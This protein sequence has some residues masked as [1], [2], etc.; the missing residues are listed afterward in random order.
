MANPFYLPPIDPGWGR[1]GEALAEGM[2][3]G[4]QNY[5][6]VRRY[7]EDQKRQDEERARQE[8]ERRRRE[9]YD[10]ARFNA[11]L[12]SLGGGRGPM[13]T[14]ES[15]TVSAAQGTPGAPGALGA[16]SAAGAPQP[17]T[18]QRRYV[19]ILEDRPDRPGAWIP[20][21]SDVEQSERL[22]RFVDAMLENAV[23]YGIDPTPY[24]SGA[25]TPADLSRLTTA[26]A[27]GALANE[28]LKVGVDPTRYLTGDQPDLAGLRSAI[29]AAIR[30]GAARRDEPTES[31][32]RRAERQR[33]WPV[34]Q[35]VF[36]RLRAAGRLPT[37]ADRHVVAQ[38]AANA[39]RAAG[40]PDYYTPLVVDLVYETYGVQMPF[41]KNAVADLVN[42]F[43]DSDQ[44]L[45]FGIPGR[46]REAV[47][48]WLSGPG[49]LRINELAL[50]YGVPAAELERE[51]RQMLG[52]Q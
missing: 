21:P 43:L 9:A 48:R 28:A 14:V 26:L 20:F 39:V 15:P 46:S 35:Q 25:Q 31:Q 19:Q 33:A 18:P 5:L 30:A 3:R 37:A 52:V 16:P 8:E 51:F 17:A 29:A 49:R 6:A 50:R 42:A 13:P 34:A 10:E 40:L 38:E 41:G 7:M 23:Q 27:A 11:W 45:L 44:A 12:A 24:L 36:E 22:R 2:S 32:I 47:E 1:V 4:A